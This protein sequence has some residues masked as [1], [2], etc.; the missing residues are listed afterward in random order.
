MD[1]YRNLGTKMHGSDGAT[2]SDEFWT[3][4]QDDNPDSLTVVVGK[5]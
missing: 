4:R 2:V 5:P 1:F 3:E